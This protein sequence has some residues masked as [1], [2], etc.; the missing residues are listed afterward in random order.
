MLK[1][2]KIIIATTVTNTTQTGYWPTCQAAVE[3]WTNTDY[4]DEVLV[5]DGKSDDITPLIMKSISK[6]VVLKSEHKWPIDMWNWQNL[7][8]QYDLIYKYC[9]D[10]EDDL[11]MIY[12]S[13]DQVI[14]DN[15]RE[16]LKNALIILAEND[17][18]DY[19]LLP[20]AK[21]INY[22]FI[23]RPYGYMENFHLHS[24]LKFD[25]KRRWLKV[26]G[27]N[28]GYG[29]EILIHE[30]APNTKSEQTG[31]KMFYNFKTTPICYD[32]FMFTID[33]LDHKI[34]RYGRSFDGPARIHGKAEPWPE[35]YKDYLSDIWLKKTI[36][37]SPRKIPI[38]F[39]P[40]EMRKVICDDLDDT[41]FGYSCF[42]LLGQQ[43]GIGII[44]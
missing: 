20:F 11:I 33:N 19:F 4:V 12:L 9:R 1:D 40:I 22:E 3:S 35:D 16:E 5:A 39:H 13:S 8:D 37:L 6:K 7:Y 27:K 44:K 25:K 36:N 26:R 29:E 15:F 30:D 24:A 23:T 34:Q 38:N 21:T 43:V 28:D 17:T 42:G 41:R 14:G 31:K 32:M 18:V 10:Q 2:K